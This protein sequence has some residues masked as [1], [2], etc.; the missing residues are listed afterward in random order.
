M[1]NL[2]TVCHPVIEDVYHKLGIRSPDKLYY[3]LTLEEDLIFEKDL[4]EYIYN[5]LFPKNLRHGML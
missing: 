4:R 5:N 3:F 1:D 2:L